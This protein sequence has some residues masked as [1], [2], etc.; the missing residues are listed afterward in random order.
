LDRAPTKSRS[1]LLFVFWRGRSLQHS[2]RGPSTPGCR[3]LG[4]VTSLP[5]PRSRADPTFAEAWYNLGDL[6]DEQGRSET[7]IEC[8]RTALRVAPDYADAM[9]N[10]A[11]LLQRK[12][13]GVLETLRAIKLSCP[14]KGIMNPQI[15]QTVLSEIEK[16]PERMQ[17]DF[18]V[19]V[20]VAMMKSWPCPKKKGPHRRG[21]GKR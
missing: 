1:T 16:H 20:R 14:P 7:A 8:L 4:S 2:A 11:L 13:V 12:T 9:F 21:S 19:P 17:E 10:L 3:P 18:V 5:G 6:L 15:V